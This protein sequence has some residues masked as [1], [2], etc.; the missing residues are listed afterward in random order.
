MS[1][2]S[3]S[4][5]DPQNQDPIPHRL[6]FQTFLALLVFAVAWRLFYDNL[7]TQAKNWWGR[8]HLPAAVRYIEA[9]DWMNAAH[10]VN[11]ATY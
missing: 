2:D 7:V 5:V 6:L 11:D 10:E 8:R 1:P 4:P 9:R 3:S